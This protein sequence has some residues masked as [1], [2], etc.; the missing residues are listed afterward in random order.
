MRFCKAYSEF[1]G[2]TSGC[3]IPPTHP[4][5]RLTISTAHSLIFN[6]PGDSGLAAGALTPHLPVPCPAMKYTPT[7]SPISPAPHCP[8]TQILYQLSSPGTGALG[9]C[10]GCLCEPV[11][12]DGCQARCSALGSHSRPEHGARWGTPCPLRWCPEPG[13]KCRGL[14]SPAAVHESCSVNAAP[15][16][17]AWLGPVVPRAAKNR[18]AGSSCPEELTDPGKWQ[19]CNTLAE[20]TVRV[21]NI[22]L[23]PNFGGR[24]C[25]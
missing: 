10:K 7:Q 5:V 23:V 2:L 21:A 3:C 18:V 12:G 24:G 1:F 9:A 11:V 25:I 4:C 13:Q 16:S 22:K 8:S 20:G 14:D 17:P 6:G 19:G 15:R